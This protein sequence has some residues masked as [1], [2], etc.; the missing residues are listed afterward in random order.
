MQKVSAL[1]STALTE[2]LTNRNEGRLVEFLAAD[3]TDFTTA[4]KQ[5]WVNTTDNFLK[6][7]DDGGVNIIA[8]PTSEQFSEY[9][10]GLNDHKSD[11]TYFPS[12]SV[13]TITEKD[14]NN[15]VISTTTFTYK[16]NGDVDTSV[17]VMNGQTVTAQYVYD[18]ND[19]LT[20][21]IKTKS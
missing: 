15:V 12:G 5:I 8:L 19:N 21:I 14:K 11:F 20:G 4:P 1:T 18:S 17:K 10:Y 2:Y 9:V 3:P 13:E 6:Y 16:V 7:T